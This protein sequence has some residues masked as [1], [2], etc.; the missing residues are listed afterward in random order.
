MYGWSN[1]GRAVLQILQYYFSPIG[2]PMWSGVRPN[3]LMWQIDATIWHLTNGTLSGQCQN[4]SFSQCPEIHTWQIYLGIRRKLVH[5]CIKM[6]WVYSTKHKMKRATTKLDPGKLNTH[7]VRNDRP[8][9]TGSFCS[10]SV[11]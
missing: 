2:R 9:L 8:K 10:W 6:E 5:H 4:S 1:V 7:K 3:H 11:L